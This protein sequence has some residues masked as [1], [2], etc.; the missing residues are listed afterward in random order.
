[1]QVNIDK[2]NGPVATRTPQSR[3]SPEDCAKM[4]CSTEE[5]LKP[6]K[7]CHPGYRN[8]L[9][10]RKDVSDTD[11]PLSPKHPLFAPC[12][13]RQPNLY[14]QGKGSSNWHLIRARTHSKG[15]DGC[16]KP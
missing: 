13:C 7:P 15:M 2:K 5:Q 14:S 3:D 8:R 16:E 12:Q 1:M 6:H 10:E 9:E 4:K 11:E